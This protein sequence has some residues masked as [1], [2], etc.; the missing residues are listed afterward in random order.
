MYKVQFRLLDNNSVTIFFNTMLT[1]SSFLKSELTG[2][3]EVRV[4]D[5]NHKC[6]W[7]VDETYEQVIAKIEAAIAS[8]EA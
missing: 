6:G 2:E 3:I 4:F 8:T 5:G 7:Y 1:V